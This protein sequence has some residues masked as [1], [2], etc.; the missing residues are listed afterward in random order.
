MLLETP[1]EVRTFQR[2]L[3]RKAKSDPSFRF[4]ALYDK[5]YRPDILNHAFDLVS[6]NKG[7]PGIDGVSFDDL[8]APGAIDNLLKELG[9]ALKEKRYKPQAVKRVMIPK[10]NGEQRPLGIPTIRDRVAQMAVK[11]VIEPIFEADFEEHSYGFRP[12]RGAHMAMKDIRRNLLIGRREVLDA[13]LSKYFDTIPHAKLMKV[14]AERIVD[15]S[16]LEILNMWLKAPIVTVDKNGKTRNIGGGK[17]NRLGTPQ[18]GVISPLLANL[19]LHILDRIWVRHGLEKRLGAR[20]VRYADDFVVLCSRGTDE[21][22]RIIKAVLDR[23]D[24]TL[25]E[26]K[27]YEVNAYQE[28]FQFLG[29][30]TR[31]RTSDRTGRWYPHT[32]PSKKSI[33]KIK[34]VIKAQTRKQLSMVPLEE[35]VESLNQRLQGWTSYF[36]FENSSQVMAKLRWYLEQRFRLHLK[37]RYKISSWTKTYAEFPNKRLYEEFNLFRIPTFAKWR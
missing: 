9:N 3:Y 6:R 15:S 31:M 17:K 37:Y 16:M 33:K 2:K 21:A 18:G 19:Y 20:I 5:I 28:G 32:E 14:V 12:K 7:G 27:T 30:V 22:R 10:G 34:S 4:Y 23:L 25:N 36:H 26:T 8:K 1:E 29:F 35:L 13:D 11:I 24:L